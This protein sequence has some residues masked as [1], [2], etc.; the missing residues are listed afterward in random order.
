MKKN[1]V[2]LIHKHKTNHPH[3][4][5]RLEINGA[6]ES[7][8]IPKR[9]PRIRHIKRLAIQT[10]PHPLSYAKFEGTIPEGSYGAGEVKIWDKGNFDLI[11]K[12]KDVIVVN[13]NG[14]KLNGEYCLVKTDYGKSPK[15]KWLFFRR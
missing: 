9:P 11:E 12:K 3:Y 7:W 14:E 8:A 15:K 1:P 4:D 13:I 5:L 2:Y 10:K 6:L